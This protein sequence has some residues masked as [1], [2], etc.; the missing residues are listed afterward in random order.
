MHSL[1]TEITNI[2]SVKKDPRPRPQP[3]TIFPRGWFVIACSDALPPRKVLSLK[4]FGRQLVLWRTAS[5]VPLLADAYCPHLGADLG[6]G[7][8]VIDELLRCP[9][10][11]FCFDASGVCVSTPYPKSTPPKRAQL[12]TWPVVERGSFIFTYFDP[13]GS[14]PSWELPVLDESHYTPLRSQSWLMSGHPQDILENSVDFGHLTELHGYST[15]PH[16][17]VSTNGPLLRADATIERPGTLFTR[18]GTT[19]K[20]QSFVWGLG[21]SYVDVHV[22][23]QD[24]VLRLYVL[25]TPVIPGQVELWLAVKLKRLRNRHRVH[26]LLSLIPQRLCETFILRQAFKAYVTDVQKDFPV[27]QNKVYIEIP[28]LAQGDGPI[29]VY[30]RWARQFYGELK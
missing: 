12:V 3:L 1:N 23:A 8:K 22:A 17:T 7:G 24:L 14:L 26:P 2:S 19:A 5:G 11:G 15:L 27:W 20:Y 21:V 13:E 10:H 9:F 25:V 28:L 18:A 6:H 4:Y 30:R 29:P 16:A